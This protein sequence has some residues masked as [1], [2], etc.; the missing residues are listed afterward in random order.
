M[1]L[2]DLYSH[3]YVFLW[4]LEYNRVS[5]AHPIFLCVNCTLHTK[6]GNYVLLKCPVIMVNAIPTLCLCSKLY[7]KYWL[8]PSNIQ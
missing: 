3:Y 5:Q 7:W 4:Y 1:I 2:D 6:S 8:K